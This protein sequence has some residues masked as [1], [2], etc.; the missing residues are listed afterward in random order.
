MGQI[1]TTITQKICWN[2]IRTTTLDSYVDST[3]YVANLSYNYRKIHLKML[4][5]L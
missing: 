3:Y 5:L 2:G 4:I 1:N